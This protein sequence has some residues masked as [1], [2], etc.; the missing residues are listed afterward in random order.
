MGD[1]R[2]ARGGGEPS[3]PKLRTAIP[4]SHVLRGSCLI[5]FSQ[6][7][8]VEASGDGVRVGHNP[9]L[10]P[11]PHPVPVSF[12]ARAEPALAIAPNPNP[13][14]GTITGIAVSPHPTAPRS[15]THERRLV[16]IEPRP[17]VAFLRPLLPKL[18]ECNGKFSRQL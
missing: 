2:L 8:Q 14:P 7:R 16:D 3:P 6:A 18:V 13:T 10:D 17:V 11:G 1:M 4:N 12:P 5:H 9:A 15:P